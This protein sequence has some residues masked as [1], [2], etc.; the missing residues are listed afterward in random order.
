PKRKPKYG[1]FSCVGYIYRYLWEQERWL[2]VNGPLTVVITVAAAAL[3]LYTPSLILSALESATEF[4]YV[5][6]VI[7]GLLIAGFFAEFINEIVSIR[8]NTGEMYMTTHLN[9]L[10][11][12]KQCSRDWYHQY[13]ESVQKLDERA[14]NA[15]QSNHA[16][17]VHLPMDFAAIVAIILNFLL[18]GAV[19]SMLHP[20]IVVLLAAG[21]AISWAMSAWERNANY[22][23]M[24][25]RN[26]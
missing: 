6:L 5:A 1:L 26:A 9:Y 7:T 15:A 23:Q 8:N 19:V 24:D 21:C 18:F 11:L 14:T 16:A 12:S 13:S 22:Q 20:L 10:L 25:K 3:A 2:A 4:G 17:G